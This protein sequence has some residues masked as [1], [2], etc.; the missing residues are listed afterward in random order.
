MF[1][2]NK[3]ITLVALVI[4]IIV[5][6][7]LAGITLMLALGDNGI[8][9]QGTKA[10]VIQIEAEVKEQM[11]LAILSAKTEML[12]QVSR[13]PDRTFDANAIKGYV[14]AGLPTT[15]VATSD[16]TKGYHVS[17]AA[18]SGENAP[19]LVVTIKYDG[20]RYQT[21]TDNVGATNVGATITRTA[22]VNTYNLSDNDDTWSNYDKDAKTI[23]G[24]AQNNK[25]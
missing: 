12:A 8:L 2:S 22:N 23:S 20:Q 17:V 9:G 18:G 14:E 6:L 21:A 4:T 11:Q 19:A 10:R 7:I 13:Y 3:G 25:I 5:L 1:K 16:A 24:T 15:E